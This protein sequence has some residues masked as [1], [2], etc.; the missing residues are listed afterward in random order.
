MI[1]CVTVILRLLLFYL[2][3]YPHLPITQMPFFYVFFLGVQE[4]MMSV[5]VAFLQARLVFYFN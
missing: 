5:A 4:G 2:V 1:M 3:P